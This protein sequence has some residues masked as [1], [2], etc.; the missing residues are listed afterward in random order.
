MGAGGER[1][2]RCWENLGGKGG[3]E[4]TGQ[5][6]TGPPQCTLNEGTHIDIKLWK[7]SKRKPKVCILNVKK[8]Q[9]SHFSHI[10]LLNSLGLI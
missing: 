8:G 5:S 10:F 6:R 2:A 4:L 7:Y 1:P 3:I 9:L